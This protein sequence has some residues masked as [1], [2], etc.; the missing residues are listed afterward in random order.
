MFELQVTN[1][2]R[3]KRKIYT[4]YPLI[5]IIEFCGKSQRHVFL[6]VGDTE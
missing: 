2:R 4:R 3:K 5:N 6:I 1:F